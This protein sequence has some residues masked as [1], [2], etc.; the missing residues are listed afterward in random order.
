[1]I[2]SD[3]IDIRYQYEK[4]ISDKEVKDS[5]PQPKIVK[6][7]DN[8]Y[9]FKIYYYLPDNFLSYELIPF[10]NPE[11]NKKY[12]KYNILNIHDSNYFFKLIKNYFIDFTNR[13]KYKSYLLIDYI[14]IYNFI[15]KYVKK[16]KRILEIKE[17]DIK[18]LSNL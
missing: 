9:F 6:N 10:S 12:C 11:I 1:M 18:Y 2:S 7:D 13:Y 15:I 17:L 3:I 5:L 8:K 4:T 16:D 14:V